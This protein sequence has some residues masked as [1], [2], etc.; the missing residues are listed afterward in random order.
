MNVRFP[1]R[2]FALAASLMALTH[3]DSPPSTS[4]AGAGNT[5]PA[6]IAKRLTSRCPCLYVANRVGMSVNV[7]SQSATGDATP[8]QS[9][10]GSY[11]ELS[12]PSDV[13]VDASGNI[14][15]SNAG[16]DAVTVYPAGA[17]GNVPPT[18]TI[19]GATTGLSSPGGI[20]FSPSDGNIYA[21]DSYDSR[22]ERDA[23][24][25]YPPGSTG[26][27]APTAII[28]GRRTGINVPTEI[29]F[30]ASGKLYVPNVNG[31]S[32]TVYRTGAS[33]NAAPMQT[34]WG[35][36]TGLSSP[37]GVAVDARR[38]IYVANEGDSITVY[39]ARATGNVAPIQTIAG[40]KTELNTPDGIVLDAAG[41]IYVTNEYCCSERNST[42]T[43]YRG[44]ARGNVRPINT[45]RGPNTALNGPSGI[46]I[47]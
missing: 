30:D 18:Q 43:V 26:N 8:I 2:T 15:V 24:T 34:I 44:S 36:A 37:V 10:S 27:V 21:A 19:S 5:L 33:G 1:K 13:A 3:C 39:A 45:I 4:A 6:G 42:I 35:Y 20:A 32:V 16:S 9:I 28:Q 38:R 25:I 47:H 41:D 22:R 29:R 23:V 11:T 17:T 40:D 46:A 31:E 12:Y 7:Y 14:Y